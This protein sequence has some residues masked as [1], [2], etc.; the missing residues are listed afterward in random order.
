MSLIKFDIEIDT[1]DL[2]DFEVLYHKTWI[3][4]SKSIEEQS[5]ITEVNTTQLYNL[6][7]YLE[8]ILESKRGV[9]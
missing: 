3:D 7:K 5:S 6:M 8:K 4:I 2:I 1:L 9:K